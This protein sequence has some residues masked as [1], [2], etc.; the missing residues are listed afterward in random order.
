[1]EAV[2]GKTSGSNLSRAYGVRVF[3]QCVDDVRGPT[4]ASFI[5]HHVKNISSLVNNKKLN[6][7]VYMI[8][9]CR[10]NGRRERI[11]TSSFIDSCYVLIKLT[12][13]ISFDIH[14]AR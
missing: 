8:I 14:P 2:G 7:F 1:M 11:I 10:G 3:V 5:N 6:R 12:S 4:L 9:V 13:T